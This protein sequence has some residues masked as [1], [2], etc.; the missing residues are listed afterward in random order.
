MGRPALLCLLSTFSL[1]QQKGCMNLASKSGNVAAKAEALALP[2]AEELGL[3]LWDVRFV[4]EGADWFLRFFIDKEGGV[5][6]NDCE[7]LSRAL[8]A[9]LDEADFI[10]QAY[11]LEVSSPGLNREL[12]KD[13]HFEQM[14]GEP[15]I[16]KLYRAMDGKKEV[17]G[18]LVGK[19]DE[20]LLLGNEHEEP[21]SLPLS[22]IASVRLDDDHFFDF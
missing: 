5:N 17:K 9:P 7:N 20:A 14:T 13:R 18:I 16:V 3:N 11:Y 15:V 12:T 2:F 1:S 10:E 22:D 4:K 19:T 6:I 21:L 8:D